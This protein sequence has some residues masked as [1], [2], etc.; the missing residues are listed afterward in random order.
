MVLPCLLCVEITPKAQRL[1][2]VVQIDLL[3]ELSHFL[4]TFVIY[5]KDYYIYIVAKGVLRKGGLRYQR[6]RYCGFS[7]FQMRVFLVI[8]FH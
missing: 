8:D 3:I 1:F 7:A 2:C 4:L 5:I 6:H